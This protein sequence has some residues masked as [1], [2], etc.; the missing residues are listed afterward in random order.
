MMIGKQGRIS[1]RPG[2]GHWRFQVSRFKRA[3]TGKPAGANFRSNTI[4]PLPRGLIF[5]SR[6]W[7]AEPGKFMQ[8]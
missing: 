7:K 3:S 8:S 6:G 1:L 4:D 2:W 5:D